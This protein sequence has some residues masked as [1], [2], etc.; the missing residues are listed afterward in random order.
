MLA[1]QL[2]IDT[3]LE[4]A[5]ES[6]ERFGSVTRA[7]ETAREFAGRLDTATL[8]AAAAEFRSLVG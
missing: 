4:V 1:F 2:E 5:L 7:F 8:S 6:F 3:F